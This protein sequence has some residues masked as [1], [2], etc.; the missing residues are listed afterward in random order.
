MFKIY[1]KYRL[2]IAHNLE[3]MEQ[4]SAL[5]RSGRLL[6]HFEEAAGE[7]IPD[8]GNARGHGRRGGRAPHGGHRGRRRGGCRGGRVGRGVHGPVID[9]QDEQAEEQPVDEAEPQ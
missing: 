4:M 2:L 5:R 9:D 6:N 8:P 3:I 1:D 7:D